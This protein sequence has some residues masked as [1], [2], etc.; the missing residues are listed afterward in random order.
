MFGFAK[1]KPIKEISPGV[2]HDMIADKE[3]VVVDVREPGEYARG[4]LPGAINVPL[5]QFDASRLPDPKGKTIVLACAGGI[6]SAKALQKC[7]PPVDTH[8]RGGLRAWVQ[9]GLPVER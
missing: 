4:H 3:A 8:L 9:A 2:L 6:R 1:R 7:E 5:S